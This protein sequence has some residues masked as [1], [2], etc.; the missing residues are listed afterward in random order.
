MKKTII[1]IAIAILFINSS[2]SKSITPKGELISKNKTI[3]SKAAIISISQIFELTLSDDVEV[4]EIEITSHENIFEYIKLESS[5]NKITLELKDRHYTY[6]N[7]TLK[8]V[9]SSKQF[10]DLRAS[11]ASSIKLTTDV[12]FNN[13]NIDLSGASCFTGKVDIDNV[14]TVLSGASIANISGKCNK[15]NVDCS[16]AS[17]V[18][19]F[20]FICNDVDAN[21]SGAS[22]LKVTAN[23]S[24]IGDISGASGIQYKGTPINIDVDT[25]GASSIKNA[26]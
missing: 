21:I 13:Y 16:G 4:G 18:S 23:N 8:A 22:K 7:L 12:D 3:S 6:R 19:G 20:N 1:L 26:N 25:S 5:D 11:G 2:C 14:N 24:L 9:V 17:I 10:N 15:Y